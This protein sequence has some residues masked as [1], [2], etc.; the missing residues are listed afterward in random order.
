VLLGLA[1]RCGDRHAEGL[2][3]HQRGLL[4]RAAGDGA[5][6]RRQWER[7]LAALAGTDSPVAGELREPLAEV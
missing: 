7:A 3:R 6:A 4:H 2:A 1:T 5:G